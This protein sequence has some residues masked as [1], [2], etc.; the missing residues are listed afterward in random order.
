VEQ[1]SGPARRHQKN[2]TQQSASYFPERIQQRMERPLQRQSRRER[3]MRIPAGMGR[4][5]KP[6]LTRRR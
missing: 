4:S 5:E 1:Y 2:L 6:L 3:F